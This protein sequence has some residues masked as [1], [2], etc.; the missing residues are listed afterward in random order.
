MTSLSGHVALITGCSR[1]TGV[2]RGAARALARAGADLV[3]ADISPGGTRN[4]DCDGRDEEEAG[5][6]GL[7]SLAEEV[8][9]YG[10]RAVTTTGNVGCRTDAERMVGEG[11]R[12][13]GK[14]DILVNNAV[15]PSGE[16]RQVTWKVPDASFDEVMRVNFKGVF[17]MSSV[18]ARHLVDRS[19]TG[20][21]INVSSAIGLQPTAER[22][23][24]AAA[25]A[26]GIALMRAMALELGP[27][28]V[29][30]NAV[31]PGQLHTSRQGPARLATTSVCRDRVPVGRLTS[32][33]DVARAIVFLA[34]PQSDH[35]TG[36]CLNVNGGA[37][38]L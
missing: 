37:Y 20:R 8:A 34:D 12:A 21:I 10:V 16:D 9:G 38:L 1:L 35:I 3:L 30:V 13:L 2:G 19:L 29:T 5:W 36:E 24:Y 17:L 26:A 28:G 18:V 31:L 32:V 33:D 7:P 15:A 25:K 4:G 22:G 6:Q 23:I 14:V 27:H 11:I